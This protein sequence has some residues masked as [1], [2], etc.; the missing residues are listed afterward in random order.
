MK[1]VKSL[2]FDGTE[3]ELDEDR[4]HKLI[5]N[6]LLV[7]VRPKLVEDGDS[8]KYVHSGSRPSTYF[9]KF[10]YGN[11]KA[12]NVL[13][14][15]PYSNN[16]ITE[17]LEYS[18]MVDS[19]KKLLGLNSIGVRIITMKPTLKL[20]YN[21]DTNKPKKYLLF[22]DYGLGVDSYAKKS[23]V[24]QKKI[25]TKLIVYDKKKGNQFV[26][27]LDKHNIK[28]YPEIVKDLVE[29]LLFRQMIQTND[30]NLTNILIESN[31]VLS[32]DENYSEDLKL[33]RFFSH[34]QKKE[35]TDILD[36]YIKTNKSYLNEI[37]DGWLEIIKSDTFGI[38]DKFK[39]YKLNKW[40]V[41][42]I[43]NVN[44]LKIFLDKNEFTFK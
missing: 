15:G 17:Q 29:I 13:V 27:W 5:S 20:C 9:G 8:F 41:K 32:I 37:L 30:T 2:K 33:D 14:K 44:K 23:F 31:R 1:I 40:N 11:Y 34:H 7:N 18:A 3:L 39:F 4:E 12:T 35:L 43:K 22:N 42:L 26:K 19:I 38:L 36:E 10:E 21:L 25:D 24:N 28:D 6:P 16:Y